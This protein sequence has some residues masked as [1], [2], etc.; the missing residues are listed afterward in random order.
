MD[1][2]LQRNQ[3]LPWEFVQSVGDFLISFDARSD[4]VTCLSCLELVFLL[5]RLGG[6]PFPAQCPYVELALSAS[7]PHGGCTVEAFKR[8][9]A[10]FVWILRFSGSSS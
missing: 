3:H 2:F 1:A 10:D 8:A 6:V 7:T 9:C 4:G 5:R